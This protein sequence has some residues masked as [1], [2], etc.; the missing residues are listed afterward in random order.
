MQLEWGKHMIPTI[1]HKGN[2]LL[3]WTFQELD[4]LFS[5]E[6]S[7]VEKPVAFLLSKTIEIANCLG[8]QA[9]FWSIYLFHKSL[10]FCCKLPN[11]KKLRFLK[12]TNWFPICSLS[13]R[14]TLLNLQRVMADDENLTSR[15]CQGSFLLKIRGDL[16]AS[17][18]C[19]VN[20]SS[21]SKY[22]F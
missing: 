7:R 4:P 15:P 9:P 22:A 17:I 2:S 8:G 16:S 13:P 21:P 6:K 12:K 14:K 18:S 11:D 5:S 19:F 1:H 10:F 20:L 3:R